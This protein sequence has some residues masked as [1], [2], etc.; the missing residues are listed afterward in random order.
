MAEEM[1]DV[2]HRATGD[3]RPARVAAG[4]ETDHDVIVISD[5]HL[6]AGA[7]PATGIYDVHEDFFAGEALCRFL[8]HLRA[9]GRREGRRWRLVILGDFVDFLQVTVDPGAERGPGITSEAAS[10]ARLEIVGRGHAAAFA[11]VASFLADD[12]GHRLDIVLGNHDVE[13]I[14]PAVQTCLRRLIG[15]EDDPERR[16][17]VDFHP[18][19]LFLPGRLYA[20]HGHQYD[21]INSFLTPLAPFDPEQPRLIALP[22]GSYF[23]R[24]L[25][26]AIERVD[27]FAD[28]VKPM[29]R[30]L[31][32]ALRA[33]PILTLTTLPSHLRLFLRALRSTTPMPPPRRHA[34]R[35]RYRRR[36]L[37]PAAQ[38]IGLPA[39]TLTEIDAMAAV[40]T[41]TSPWE[42]FKALA[43]RPLGPTAVGAATITAAWLGTGRLR[44][45]ARSLRLPLAGLGFLVWREWPL[46]HPDDE[47]R[48]ALRAAATAIATLLADA[49]RQAARAATAATAAAPAPRY[50]VPAYVF[51][52][53]HTAER[54]PLSAERPTP[55]YLNSGTWTPIVPSPFSLIGSREL[56][57]FVEITRDQETGQLTPALLVWND[58]AERAEPLRRGPRRS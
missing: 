8:D 6:S 56:L 37:W 14:W 23:V 25:F 49:D 11:A 18:W 17:R 48:N 38:R 40:P 53:T 46:L 7:D 27:P 35:D 15:A 3:G 44:E 41:M 32:W 20:E 54:Y 34:V 21:D 29:T 22:L 12:A 43:L 30:Y 55:V 42:Q 36:V 28:N 16:Q 45:P 4:H 31:T 26:N 5:L 52:H 1:I 39:E 13:F 19:I 24:Y 50:A 47:D 51:G 10:V 57:S 58:A 33:H 9:R 2:A